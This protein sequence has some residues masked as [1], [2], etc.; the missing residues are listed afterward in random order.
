MKFQPWVLNH[1]WQNIDPK[2]GALQDAPIRLAHTADLVNRIPLL[3]PGIILVR[4]P[5]QMGKST[6]LH[7]F[8][9][10]CLREAP[11][12]PERIALFDVERFEDRHALL[13]AL[14]L[15]IDKPENQCIILLDEL[16]SLPSW[17]LAIKILADSGMLKNALVLGTGSSTIDIASGGDMLPG[18]RGSRYPVD[19]ELLPVPYAMVSSR[20]SIDEYLLTGGCPWSISEYLRNGS[21]P[22]FVYELYASWIR[23]CFDKKRHSIIQLPSL[24]QA[25]ALHQ[26]SSFSVH[27]LVRDCGIGS[28]STGEMYLDMLE[29]IYAIIPTCWVPPSG[30]PP[31]PR[32]NRKVYPLDPFLHHIFADY[33]RGWESA[34]EASIE[35]RADPAV[36]GKLVE[37]LVAS[38]LRRR[39][40]FPK[41][42]YWQGKNEID[43]VTPSHLYEVKYQNHV[44]INE[45][46][47]VHAHMSSS[48]NM[49]VITKRDNA[50]DGSLRLVDLR[51]WLLEPVGG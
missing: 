2:L 12:P 27:K 15:F 1:N 45:F 23:G 17:W 34:F 3:P 30:A 20:L 4:G 22:A 44:S 35:R 48:Q 38:E 5:R 46:A 47:W 49:T 33:N 10:K 28:N 42:G 37:G 16:T 7:E 21:I 43:F 29:R 51:T 13:A 36:C 39:G 14:E 9:V 26:S 24:L 18:R 11:I 19:F 32:K 6:F 40:G 50:R 31:A 8:A 25:L 41:L